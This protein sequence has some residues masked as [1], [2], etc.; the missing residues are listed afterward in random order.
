MVSEDEES[1]VT[2]DK[3]SGLFLSLVVP[4]TEV[5]RI[6][7]AL[8]AHRLLDKSL[9][10]TPFVPGSNASVA[11]P[12]LDLQHSKPTLNAHGSHGTNSMIHINDTENN[13]RSGVGSAR[14]SL[15]ETPEPK[16]LVPTNVKVDGV[17]RQNYAVQANQARDTVLRRIAVVDQAGIEAHLAFRK[18]PRI[19]LSESNRSLL[20]QAVHKW[21]HCLPPGVRS[22]LPTNLDGLL[23]TCRWTY[24][25][26]SSML[27]LPPTFLSKDPWPELL[28]KFLQPYL[29][30]L[31]KTICQQLKVTH[32][33]INGSIPGCLPCSESNPS[34][35]NILRSPSNLVP[36]HGDFGKPDLSPTQQNLDE[37][38]WVGTVQ[39]DITQI[40]APLYT[41]FSRG[42]FKEKTRLL[43]LVLKLFISSRDAV[44]REAQGSSAVDLYAGI[45]YFAFSYA[46]AGVGKVLCW[47]LNGWSIEGLRRGAKKNG[48]TVKVVE[49]V[50]NETLLDDS[51]QEAISTGDERFLVFH[52]S[53]MNAAKRVQALR[54]KI[55]PIRHVNCGYL[56]LSKAS[57]DVA[58]KVLDP[59]EGGWIHAHENTPASDIERRKNEVVDIFEGLTHQYRTQDSASVFSVDCHH[60]EQVKAYAPGIIHCV[61]DIAILPASPHAA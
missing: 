43:Q 22:K 8:E 21:L 15:A 58:V 11:I 14:P 27:L 32:I 51:N 19:P 2:L 25:V 42:N 10:I 45:G 53:N 31:Y 9:K 3:L 17:A 50:Q 49:N 34:E 41:M 37:A 47:E 56:P 44:H 13:D 29:P 33:A 23:N 35:S 26:Y 30:E 46:K 52:E 54:S 6:K 18:R 24:T 5:K 12:R 7:N 28:A 38:L 57:W 39:N 59:T 40:W 61:F 16:F 20:A 4:K 55:P 1:N 48:W 36:L 60:V